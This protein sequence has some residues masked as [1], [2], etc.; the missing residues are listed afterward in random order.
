MLTRIAA[1]LHVAAAAVAIG[2]LGSMYLR[3]LVLDYRAGWQST[4]LQA[5][6]VQRVLSTLLAPATAL[7]G[8]RRAGR[9]RHARAAGAAGC[10]DRRDGIG[11]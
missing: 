8:H 4:F 1:L 11:R 10:A 2:L 7:T 9:C 3:G 5:D 6:T